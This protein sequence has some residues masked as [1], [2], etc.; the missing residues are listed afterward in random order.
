MYLAIKYPIKLSCFHIL[1]FGGI[2]ICV[3]EVSVYF[4]L[5]SKY[6]FL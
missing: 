3:H 5:I 2:K 6:I 4:V 1:S